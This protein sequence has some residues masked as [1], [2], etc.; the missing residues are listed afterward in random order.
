MNRLVLSVVVL[1]LSVAGCNRAVEPAPV[2][3]RPVRTANPQP[4]ACAATPRFSGNVQP[5]ARVDLAFKRGGYVD[6]VLRVAARPGGLVDEGDR[7][8]RGTVLARLR[9]ADYRVKLGQARA[10]LGQ[11]TAAATQATQELARAQQIFAGGGGAKA[12]VEGAENKL[13]A[14]DAQ[15][16]AASLLVEEAQLALADCELAAPLD[17][18]VVKRMVEPGNL[19][20][21]GS[22]GF[23][24]VDNSSMK[25]T[26]GVP[27]VM[28]ERVKV[29][30]RV[31]VTLDVAGATPFDAAVT[32]VA[33][34]GD[35][36][37]RLFEVEVLLPNTDGHLRAGQIAS[38][39]LEASAARGDGGAPTLAVPVNAVVRP[40]GA[41]EGFAVFVNEGGVLHPRLVQPGELCA[42]TVE[43]LGGLDAKDQVVVD[44]A[45]QSFEGERVAVVP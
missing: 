24:L 5:L 14:S 26:F 18:V 4:A 3:V 2:I 9:S 23:I 38:L 6:E 22:P 44:G 17:A 1:V 15:V 42:S 31:S 19:V 12:M 41:A 20:G 43:I 11:A 29:G 32:R 37:T 10:Q 7:V 21:P 25:V 16:R 39:Q 30:T 13:A 40:P 27:D 34:V 36:K 35:L 28:L 45:A 33:P 8:K